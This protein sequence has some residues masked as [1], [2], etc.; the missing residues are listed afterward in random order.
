MGKY[1]ILLLALMFLSLGAY[2]VHLTKSL[3]IEQENNRQLHQA[4]DRQQSAIKELEE[5]YSQVIVITQD[6]AQKS[7]QREQARE[8]VLSKLEQTKDVKQR[9]RVINDT[10]REYNRCVTQISSS[11]VLDACAPFLVPVKP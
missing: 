11:A 8:N 1:L 3:T 4:I 7:S 9:E 2:V 10:R 5:N 6:I